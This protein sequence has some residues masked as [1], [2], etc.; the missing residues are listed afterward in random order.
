MIVLRKKASIGKKLARL[1][2]ITIIGLY[3]ATQMWPL[4]TEASKKTIVVQYGD[5]EEVISVKAYIVR[6]EKVI[7]FVKD[8]TEVEFLVQEGKM[9][10]KD[11]EIAR[12]Y[13]SDENDQSVEKELRLIEARIDSIKKK[14]T[15]GNHFQS[16]IDKLNDQMEYNVNLIQDYINNGDYEKIYDV[17]ND[18]NTILE[19]KSIIS[20][21]NSFAGLNLNELE[22]QRVQLKNKL[23]SFIKIV[24]S[25]TA[26]YFALGSDGLEDLFNTSNIQNLDFESFQLFEETLENKEKQE[27]GVAIRIINNF[28]YSLVIQLDNRHLSGLSEGRLVRLREDNSSKEY[29]ARVRKVLS[30]DDEEGK[31]L[32]ILDIT[33]HME[34]IFTNRVLEIDLLKNAYEGITIPNRSIIENDGQAGVFKVDI[35]GFVKFVPVKIKGQNEDYAIVHNSFFDTIIDEESKRVLTISSFDEI[36]I[37]GEGLKDGQKIR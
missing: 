32:V 7:A 19:K 27:T 23:N 20:G 37:N 35:N 31:S 1:I 24:N 36:V 28:K 2:V 15:E 30:E 13:L 18:I 33:D 5:I 14:H 22:G 6:D 9:V 29:R 11:Q 26:G 4:F 17:K 10:A 3:F 21:S 25:N 8:Y 16:D 12:F 34:N